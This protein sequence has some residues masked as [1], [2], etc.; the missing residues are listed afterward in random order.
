[1]RKPEW[2]GTCGEVAGDCLELGKYREN[3]LHHDGATLGCLRLDG[4]EWH[5]GDATWCHLGAMWHTRRRRLDGGVRDRTVRCVVMS[6]P[7]RRGRLSS[8]VGPEA[9]MGI[10]AA[11]PGKWQSVHRRGSPDDRSSATAQ[12]LLQG[13][14]PRSD[15]LAA[16]PSSPHPGGAILSTY[17]TPGDASALLVND[18][19]QYLLHLRDATSRTGKRESGHCSEADVNPAKRGRDHRSGAAGR[20]RPHH[21]GPQTLRSHPNHHDSTGGPPGSRP[22]SACGTATLIPSHSPRA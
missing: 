21:P 11:V 17:D 10:T 1:M 8:A 7:D 13:G 20:S 2:L 12:R 18:Q 9:A 5:R 22:T 3:G 15:R 19:G 16:P 4:M 14:D 6:R